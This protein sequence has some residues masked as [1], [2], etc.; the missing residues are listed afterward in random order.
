MPGQSMPRR[1]S[2]AAEAVRLA[3]SGLLLLTATLDAAAQDLP[4]P[5]AA[6]VSAPGKS[7]NP[8]GTSDTMTDLQ[9]EVYVNGTSSDMIAHLRRTR[10]GTLLIEPMQLENVGIKPVDTARRVDGWIDISTLPGVSYEFDE[11]DQTLRFSAPDEARSTKV[12]DVAAPPLDAGE[13]YQEA[14]SAQTGTGALLNYTLYASTGGDEWSDAISFQGFSAL[15]EARAFSPW[16][17]LTSSQVVSTSQSEEFDTTRLDT[18]WSYSD[19]DKLRTVSAGDIITGGLSWTRPTRL[20][21]IRIARNFALRPDMVTMPLPEFSGSAAVPSTV[22]V[23]INNARRLSQ[24][25]APGPFAIANLP[26]VTGAGNAR[27]VVRDSLGRETVSETP[28]FASADLLAKGLWDYSAELGFARRSY[29]T[30]SNDYDERPVGSATL[31]YGLS[32]RLTLEAHAE[33]GASFY[34]LGGGGVFQLGDFAVGALSGAYSSSDDEAG[35][36]VAASIEGEVRDVHF[37]ARS[38]RTFGDY[39][40]I[41]S[42]TADKNKGSTNLPGTSFSA[43]PPRALDQVTVSSPLGFDKTNLNLAFTQLETAASERSRIVSV[44]ANRTIGE[45]GSVFVT[46]Y[47]DFEQENSF[48][49]FA[50]LSWSFGGDKSASLNVSDSDNGMAITADYSKSERPEVGSYGWRVRAGAGE[51]QLA[52]ASGSY[53]SGIGRFEAGVERVDEN[54]RAYGQLEG[55]IVAAGGDVF[56]AGRIDDAFGVVDAGAPGVDVLLENRPMGQTNRRGKIL[57][58]GLRSY[59]ENNIA[60]DPTNLPIDARID[61]TRQIVK[62]S[63]R[64]GAVVDFKVET[65]QRP[66]LLVLK[67]ETGAFVEAGSSARSADGQDLV[68]GYDGQLYLEG[69]KP[70]EW[71]DVSLPSGSTCRAQIAELVTMDAGIGKGEA[72]CQGVH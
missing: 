15:L 2:R 46:A 67:D 68:V 14:D 54:V 33:G 66:A 1:V 70:Q 71:I 30:L 64:A 49:L 63:D 51:T 32:D 40:D 17:V 42:V 18:T 24:S 11:T 34:N 5:P 57:L 12:I 53:R 23:Y 69:A 25:V 60:L 52:S 8:S 13:A 22:D 62:P 41:A 4:S 48:G 29:G 31:R 43:R 58:P 47:K 44:T 72:T 19:E 36:Q 20:G 28:F 56:L 61:R 39:N 27:V 37:S 3:A 45:T 16:G 7:A 10:A 38:Q 26:I 9:L 59:G 65:G 21:G 6:P 35:F 55:S 50:G